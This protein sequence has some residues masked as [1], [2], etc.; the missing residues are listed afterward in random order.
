MLK[1]VENTVAFY[2]RT[3]VEQNTPDFATTKASISFSSLCDTYQQLF[4]KNAILQR[5]T[6]GVLKKPLIFR[7]AKIFYQNS[8]ILKSLLISNR[9]T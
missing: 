8:Q 6:A 3:H 2:Y 4:L 1:Q 9:D 5:K 7:A